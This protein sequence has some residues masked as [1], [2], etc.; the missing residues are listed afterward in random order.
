MFN[1]F[2][3]KSKNSPVFISTISEVLDA[4]IMNNIDV[5]I[6]NLALEVSLKTLDSSDYYE[7]TLCY[8]QSEFELIDYN[9]CKVGDSK[10]EEGYVESAGM[11]QLA[12]L[13]ITNDFADDMN[14]L[15]IDLQSFS[16]KFFRS[17]LESFPDERT[18]DSLRVCLV[19]YSQQPAYRTDNGGSVS[20]IG[21]MKFN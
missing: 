19:S 1:S 18:I 6:F 21:K 20:G 16:I 15:S 5:P 8:S 14:S 17:E 13:V 12:P 10:G 7:L 11:Q 4:D 9:E 3:G 2:A